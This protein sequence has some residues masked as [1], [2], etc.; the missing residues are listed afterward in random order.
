MATENRPDRYRG[1]SLW[2]K[3]LSMK[4]LSI[5]LG[6]FLLFSNSHAQSS[7]ILQVRQYRLNNEKAIIAE[8]T[9]FLS[10]PNIASDT[11]NIR[12]NAQSLAQMMQQ[13]GIQ[14]VQF[15]QADEPAA[16]PV[17]YGEVIIPGAKRT[18]VFYAHYDGQPVDPSQWAKGLSPFVPKFFDGRLD[19]GATEVVPSQYPINPDWRIYARGSSDDKAGVMAILNA[20][21]AISRSGIQA[22]CNI[23]FFF[24]GE[25]EQGSGHLVNILDK[26]QNLLQSD[27]W[28]I[29]D[30]PIHQT[31]KKQIVFGVRGDAGI[32]IT[33][34]GPSRPLH[35]GHYGNWA[36]NPG[37]RLAKLLASMKT[38]DGKVT[39]KGFYEDMK[40]ITAIE[41]KAIAALPSVD[42]QMKK[43][44]GIRKPEMT[45]K[46]LYES[47]MLPSL[48]IR[49][50]QSANIG[51][52]ASNVIPVSATASIDLRLVPG[53]ES[54]RQQQKVIDHV[55]GQ[56]YY[57]TEK[58]PTAEERME[59]DK[60]A[61]LVRRPSYDAM[62]TPMENDFS[63]SVTSAVQ[64]A[65]KEPVLLVPTMGGSLPLVH[66]EKK[67]SA[68]IIILPIANH[69]N[70]Q[71]A[72]NENLR[73]QN[74][75]D[76]IE[77]LASVMIMP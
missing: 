40:P 68:R 21:S 56:G 72:E 65:T 15:L 33:V 46:N 52:K 53:N 74:F 47:I 31:G 9:D 69:D 1:G 58:D 11:I 62:R 36:P 71:H 57:V 48:N 28:I 64:R 77:A 49:G 24:E 76:G 60:I 43:E 38:D 32:D 61:K 50:M 17:I 70:N 63:K 39:V 29:C 18:I 41:K 22:T 7:E 8:F 73:L 75:W 42:E 6:S 67:L 27:L 44:L 5:I 16:P 25:E 4:S 55:K 66:L 51:D 12:R 26:Y 37:M 30:G 14:N 3:S 19:Q 23:K 35:S 34:Y 10:L 2:P 54:S 59:Y 20:W 13:R 45:G